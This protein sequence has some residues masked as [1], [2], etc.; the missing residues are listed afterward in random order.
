MSIKPEIV[1]R[2]KNGHWMHSQFPC[3]EVD[4]EVEIWISEAELE[5]NFVFMQSDIDE[6]HPAYI[7]YFCTDGTDFHD[8]N[9]S[10]P[11]GLG[12][13]IGGIYGA[14]DGPVCTWLRPISERLKENPSKFRN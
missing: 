10:K 3:A 1:E 8:W 13:F 4:D 2:D 5:G 12:W 6:D 7:R 11:D 9:P 14:A